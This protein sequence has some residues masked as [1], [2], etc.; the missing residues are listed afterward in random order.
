M[1]QIQFIEYS[2]I[3]R[4]LLHINCIDTLLQ[5][6]VLSHM[7]RIILE[8]NTFCLSSDS[9]LAKDMTITK[10]FFGKLC[11]VLWK[12]R[13]FSVDGSGKSFCPDMNDPPLLEEVE[14]EIADAD[15]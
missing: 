7:I 13:C 6:L 8:L 4:K 2:F 12:R 5:T 15:R 11:V 9:I 14:L 10:S 3:E 1:L